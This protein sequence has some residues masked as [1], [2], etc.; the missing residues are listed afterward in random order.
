MIGAGI[1]DEDLS[2]VNCSKKKPDNKVVIASQNS[3]FT[4]KRLV[5]TREYFEL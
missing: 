5:Q 2:I 1:F 4:L 3:E